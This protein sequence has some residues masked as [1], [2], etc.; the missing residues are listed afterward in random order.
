MMDEKVS[1]THQPT[2]II[3]HTGKN[4][5]VG[6]NMTEK[7]VKTVNLTTQITLIKLKVLLIAWILKK[8]R[9]K[10]SYQLIFSNK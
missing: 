1:N 4:K 7:V 9:K 8:T 5:E 2:I 6:G 3:M 10:D